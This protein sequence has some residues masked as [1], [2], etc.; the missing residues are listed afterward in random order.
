MRRDRIERG[1]G[2]V[3]KHT[4]SET[5]CPEVKRKRKGCT[6]IQRGAREKRR[7]DRNEKQARKEM[8]EGS[9]CPCEAK[10]LVREPMPLEHDAVPLL[11]RLPSSSTA[12]AHAKPVL[13]EALLE[14]PVKDL[15]DARAELARTLKVPR[16]DLA[17]GL[18]TLCARDGCRTLSRHERERLRV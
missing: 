6:E 11:A 12:S 4:E 18:L 2:Y 1:R 5:S 8:K 17:G 15:L 7:G 13:P 9:K 16:P 10:R 14:R 3:T